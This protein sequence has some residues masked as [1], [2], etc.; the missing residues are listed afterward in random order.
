MAEHRIDGILISTIDNVIQQIATEWSM[1][2]GKITIREVNILGRG[3]QERLGI[4]IVGM[5]MGIPGLPTPPVIVEA[6]RAAITAKDCA[7]YTPFEGLP[8]L[9]EAT[10]YFIRQ[11]LGVRVEPRNCIP[12]V[13]G[14]HGCK[15]QIGLIGRM[16]PEKDTILMLVPGFAVNTTQARAYGVKTTSLDVYEKYG[17]G[18]VDAIEERFK[19]GNIA[20]L[21][22]SSPN[23][24]TWRV[25]S[26]R[27]LEGIGKLL[28]KYDVIGIEDAAYFGLDSRM[29]NK[30]NP[31]KRPYFPSIAQYTENWVMLL[32]GSKIFNYAGERIGVVVMSEHVAELKGP[33]LPEWYGRETYWHALVQSGIYST[34]ASV[35]Q[36]SQRALAAGFRAAAD[37]E[38]PFDY[39]KYDIAY[40]QL[41]E[42]ARREFLKNGFTMPYARDDIG[43]IGFGYYFT[44]AHPSFEDGAKLAMAMLRCGMTAVPLIGFGGE[45]NEGVRL[46]TATLLTEDKYLILDSRVE[47]FKRLYG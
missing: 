34:V 39:F 30:R 22:W 14:M 10:A 33:G 44:A 45:H 47:T 18:L 16:N 32:S 1:D 43:K 24:P 5:D 46:C 20:G 15:E 28:T 9:K 11:F 3:L 19:Q 36:S 4:K 35:P 6:Q 31:G 23:N 7:Q 37:P 40:E 25:L 38:Y 26:K 8:V 13:G 21:L 29:K 17:Q 41:A 42:I 12:T 2:F 27:E